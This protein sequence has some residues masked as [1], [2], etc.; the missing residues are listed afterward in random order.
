MALAADLIVDR[1]VLKVEFPVESKRE[2][3]YHYIIIRRVVYYK[4]A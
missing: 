1:L 2:F 3:F 4:I